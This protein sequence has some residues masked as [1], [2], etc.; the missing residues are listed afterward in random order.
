MTL[1]LD[2]NP[3]ILKVHL[4]AKN[5]VYSS[6]HSEIGAEQDTYTVFVSATLA[7]VR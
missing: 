5:E 3:D 2:L 6:K 1:V 7:L 4:L